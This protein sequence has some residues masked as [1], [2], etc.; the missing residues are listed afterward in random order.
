MQFRNFMPQ[1]Q[2]Q[3]LFGGAQQ[4]QNNQI[5]FNPWL[6]QQFMQNGVMSMLGYQ[7]QPSKLDIHNNKNFSRFVNPE[8]FQ[9]YFPNQYNQ[10]QQQYGLQQAMQ[11]MFPQYAQ[12]VPSLFGNINNQFRRY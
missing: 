2:L 12:A 7:G 4:P 6:K 3:T 11:Q 9:S 5:G 10:W 1:Q 8:A